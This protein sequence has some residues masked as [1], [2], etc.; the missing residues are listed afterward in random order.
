MKNRGLFCLLLV[1][2]A[3]IAFS[4]GLFIGRNFNH[5]PVQ[6][7][8]VSTP[9]ATVPDSADTTAPAQTIDINTATFSQL[10][11]LP[12]IGPT[13]AQR[14]IDY[15]QQNGPFSSIGDLINVSGIG[16]GKL[17]AIIDYITTGG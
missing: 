16:E 13:L 5:S 12:G 1:C 3:C 17:E 11:T 7:T 8:V 6:L 9:T 15:R 4:C 2:C 10:Q 14:I